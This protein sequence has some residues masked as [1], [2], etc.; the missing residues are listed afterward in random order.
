MAERNADRGA[1]RKKASGARRACS[2]RY[3]SM[4]KNSR[5]AYIRAADFLPGGVESNFRHLDPFPFYASRAE[6]S[7]IYDIDGNEYI[8][9]LLSQ[10]AI[11]FGHRKRDIEAAVT[12][13]LK[14]GAN[15]AIPTELC[16]DVAE[17][18][19]RYVPSVR[20]LRF[21]NSGTEATM[22]ALRTARGFTGRDKIAKPEGGYHGVHDYVLLS[23]WAPEM[24][25]TE[26][27]P[28]ATPFSRGVPKA[29]EKVLQALDG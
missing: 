16:A 21:T 14:K 20:L 12:R 19:S 6:G 5:A 11:L 26:K 29:V 4:M 10:G 1:H 27:R 8:D 13:Q 2:Q 18:I 17:M 25:G 7:R 9:F 15:T 3:A 23:I 28:K 24:K 22:H